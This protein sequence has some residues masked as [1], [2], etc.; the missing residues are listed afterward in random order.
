MDQ[1]IFLNILKMIVVMTR[2][3]KKCYNIFLLI[4]IRDYFLELKN[5]YNILFAHSA[6]KK[7]S[8][9]NN[10]KLTTL[11]SLKLLRIWKLLLA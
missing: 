6:V 7:S 11:V 5:T 3:Y 2:G 1:H 10:N 8:N 9:N 4:Y